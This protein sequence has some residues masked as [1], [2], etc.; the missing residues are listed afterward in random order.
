MA[1]ER[2]DYMAF[3]RCMTIQERRARLLDVE[4]VNRQEVSAPGGKPITFI[5]EQRADD[6]A[7]KP[8]S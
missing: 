3:D 8:V 2:G 6:A 4:P 1:V 5:I 7:D